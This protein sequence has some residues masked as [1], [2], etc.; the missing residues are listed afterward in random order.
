MNDQ[1]GAPNPIKPYL[2]TAVLD[3]CRDNAATPYVIVRVDSS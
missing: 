3:Y 2:V 1:T